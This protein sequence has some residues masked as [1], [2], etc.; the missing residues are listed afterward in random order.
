MDS[1]GSVLRRKTGAARLRPDTPGEAAAVRAL[2][3]ALGRAGQAV[4]GLGLEVAGL[5]EARLSLSELLDLTSKSDAAR[6]EAQQ[7]TCD[8]LLMIAAFVMLAVTETAA[9]FLYRDVSRPLARLQEAIAAIQAC[10]D[11]MRAGNPKE[12]T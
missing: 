12:T 6:R 8:V 11:E 7:K 1:A 4:P 3:L 10:L 5:T 2:R 9:Y